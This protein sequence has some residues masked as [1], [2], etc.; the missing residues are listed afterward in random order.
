MILG[1][2]GWTQGELKLT[3]N[4]RKYQK[5]DTK[6]K[7]I[8]PNRNLLQEFNSRL[9]EAE[10]KDQWTQRQDSVTHSIRVAHTHTHQ[11]KIAE[12]TYGTTLKQRVFTLQ[13]SQRYK[14]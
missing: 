10:T 1:E 6:L 2:N 13:E 7:I 11:V 3:G 12:E 14:R 4:I 5:E 8:K 9:D